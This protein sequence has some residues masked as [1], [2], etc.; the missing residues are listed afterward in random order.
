MYY[1][2]FSYDRAK[3]QTRGTKYGN[4]VLC[5]IRSG[6]HLYIFKINIQTIKTNLFIVYKIGK[7]N[8]LQPNK[9]LY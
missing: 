4:K 5:V 8:T 6:V 1:A 2:L 7:E 9:F 3:H